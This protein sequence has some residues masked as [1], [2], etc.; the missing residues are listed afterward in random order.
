MKNDEQISTNFKI[1]HWQ[2]QN[3]LNTQ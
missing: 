1:N 2:L 3:L